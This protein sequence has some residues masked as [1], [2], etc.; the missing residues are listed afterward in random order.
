MSDRVFH[1]LERHQKLDTRLQHARARRWVD[2]FEI[3]RLKKLKLAI[4][5]RLAAITRRASRAG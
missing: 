4:K 3:A 2:P 1:L 5:D